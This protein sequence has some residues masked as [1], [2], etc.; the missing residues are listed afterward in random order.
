M[1]FKNF[2]ALDQRCWSFLS[3]YPEFD[4]TTCRYD[5]LANEIDTLMNRVCLVGLKCCR[6]LAGSKNKRDTEK[7]E[8][9]L[10]EN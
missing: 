9:A 7:I 2:F 6:Q 10:C 8:R 4:H 1:N 3:P 5:C